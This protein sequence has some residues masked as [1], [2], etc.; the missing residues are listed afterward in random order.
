MAPSRNAVPIAPSLAE[1]ESIVEDVSDNKEDHDDE[2]EFEVRDWMNKMLK[3][4]IE[5][6]KEQGADVVTY[7]VK[8][9]GTMNE[10]G[11]ILNRLEVKADFD[12]DTITQLLL[13]PSIEVICKKGYSFCT[14]IC[15]SESGAAML[16]Y[17]Y[18]QNAKN[19]MKHFVF[20]NSKLDRSHHVM[21][22]Q[23]LV[24]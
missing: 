14:I 17:V 24:E 8:N 1:K 20:I 19:T 13:S 6:L 23:E 3:E 7:Q 5:R 15:L 4:E 22:S 11:N 12:F 16:P 2:I 18:Q 21:E 9:F 10:E